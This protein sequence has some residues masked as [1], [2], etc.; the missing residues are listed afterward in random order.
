MKTVLHDFVLLSVFFTSASSSVN[1]PEQ[2]RMNF[3]VDY[4]SSKGIKTVTSMLCDGTDKSVRL[5]KL[6]S[7]NGIG[8]NYVEMKCNDSIETLP[9]KFLRLGLVIDLACYGAIEVLENASSNNLFLFENY[10]T[11]WLIFMSKYVSGATLEAKVKDYTPEGI[12][13]MDF[14]MGEYKN[15]EMEKDLLSVNR[16]VNEIFIESYENEL[17][18]P[19]E[20]NGSSTVEPEEL[21]R[22]LK[23]NLLMDNRVTFAVPNLNDSKNAFN[24]FSMYKPSEESKPVVSN[25]GSVRVSSNCQIKFV[26]NP[27]GN[28]NFQGIWMRTGTTV[29]QPKIFTTLEDLTKR[30]TDIW[31]KISYEHVRLLAQDL[32]FSMVIRFFNDYGWSSNGSFTHLMGSLQR[33]ESLLGGSAGLLRMDRLQGI[34]VSMLIL[35]ILVVLVLRVR[36]VISRRSD[37]LSD[38]RDSDFSEI[39]VYILGAIC[40]QGFSQTPK[41]ISYRIVV[42]FLLVISVVLFSLYSACIVALLQSS[43]TA[44]SSIK[45]MTESNFEV[46]IQAHF[47]FFDVLMKE[48]THPVLKRYYSKK[49]QHKRGK[50][51]FDLREGIEKMRTD[52]FA[53]EVELNAGYSLI[54]QTYQDKEKCGVRIIDLMPKPYICMPI[55]KKSS[56]KKIFRKRYIWQE[57]I[58]LFDRSWNRW[59]SQ[60]PKCEVNN[61]GFLSVGSTEFHPVLSIFLY[62]VCASLA[63]FSFELLS[64]SAYF[65]GTIKMKFRKKL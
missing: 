20:A 39:A 5:G 7:K 16:K 31:S 61:I 21:E 63:V 26:D 60:K 34:W 8:F 17:K 24:L 11:Q 62:G 65:W 36:P 59:M 22:I 32:N 54:S 14:L 25:V 45:D 43:S 12:D 19:P 13:P 44:I 56:Y 40:Q 15:K 46:G 41:T 23:L 28:R 58:G 37:L 55:A 2:I 51:H 47:P 57:E 18:P 3:I 4:F 1:C 38:S 42:F 27:E 9:S 30:E 53:F 48:A 49:I 33:K 50:T 29:F 35:I 10:P 64:K 6:L 52:L